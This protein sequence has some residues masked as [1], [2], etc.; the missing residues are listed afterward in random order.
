MARLTHQEVAF[1]YKLDLRQICYCCSK[2]RGAPSD[3]SELELNLEEIFKVRA[4]MFDSI[5]IRMRRI[6]GHSIR[7]NNTGTTNDPF[8]IANDEDVKII[9]EYASGDV[10]HV[11][12]KNQKIKT[13]EDGV[14]FHYNYPDVGV[15]KRIEEMC[16]KLLSQP[17]PHKASSDHN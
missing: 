9:L 17:F 12:F 3:Q 5:C 4:A 1:S 8:G 16:G 13:G 6:I 15:I 10:A 2:F 7:N 11:N 14:E